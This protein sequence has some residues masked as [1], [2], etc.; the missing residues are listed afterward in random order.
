VVEA[1][2]WLARAEK[3]LEKVPAGKLIGRRAKLAHEKGMLDLLSGQVKRAVTLLREAVEKDQTDPEMDQVS[4]AEF[5]DDYAK[6]LH[7]SGKDKEGNQAEQR[8]KQIR[9][10][11]RNGR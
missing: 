2:G 3:I 4:L 10:L 7:Q 8:A 1:E 6:V 11:L 5:L 9:D